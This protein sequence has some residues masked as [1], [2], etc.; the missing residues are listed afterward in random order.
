MTHKS[1]LITWLALLTYAII[2]GSAFL[3]TKAA[4]QSTPPCTLAALRLSIGSCGLLLLNFVGFGP[5]ETLATLDHMKRPH[6]VAVGLLNTAIPYTL[7]A[8]AMH[9]FG[10]QV[11]LAAAISGC[12]PLIAQILA[13]V[14]R[15]KRPSRLVVA[16]LFVG[17]AGLALLSV[18]TLIRPVG[19]TGAH[20]TT[21][22]LGVLVQIVAVSSKAAAAVIAQ[23]HHEL[24]GLIA[25]K[26]ALVQA[27]VGALLALLLMAVV[28][29]SPLVGGDAATTLAPLGSWHVW[30][31]L[32]YLGLA[33]SC[34]VYFLQFHLITHV[35]AV[36]QM[37]V[38][39]LTPIVG[40]AEGGFFRCDFC[41]LPVL[42]TVL[43]AAGCLLALVGVAL[44]QH[45]PQYSAA[46]AV[47]DVASPAHSPAD[48]PALERVRAQSDEAANRG[49]VQQG[50]HSFA[51]PLLSA[52]R[53]T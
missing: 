4:T 7:Y 43:I 52:Y 28:D 42:P 15:A 32:L 12:T 25:P 13:M 38:D 14:R 27:V 41:D 31:A 8:Y 19:S 21:T 23:R 11:W 46:A 6:A 48:A 47:H 29:L 30:P 37:T 36:R 45:T 35:G 51:A 1:V 22:A 20:R 3:F 34:V 18:A 16:G 5:R 40:V 50:T 10:V 53:R 2:A 33:S 17:L 49:H 24:T 39:Y 9:S 44:S 26:L